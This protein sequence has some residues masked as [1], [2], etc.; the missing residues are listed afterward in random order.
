MTGSEV[1]IGAAISGVA[2]PVFQSLWQGGGRA[3][4]FFGKTLDDKTKEV[5]FQASKQYD[6]NY[7]ERHGI[8]KVLGMREAVPLESVY[9]TVQ[10][11]G[12]EELQGLESV[13]ALEAAYREFKRRGFSSKN[14]RKRPG[15]KVV[16]EKQFLMVLGGPGAG[17][18]T[19]LRRMGLEALKG[20]KGKYQHRCIPVLIELKEF[21]TGEVNIEQKIAEEFRV[22]GFPDHQRFTAKAL[23]RQ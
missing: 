8:L 16:N 4:R 15:L 6:K 2:V 10:F 23:V 3:I 20:T 13:E 1:L 19:F 21:R 17:K 14:Q 7:F 18:S 9:T 11:L 22:C 12:D 5:I